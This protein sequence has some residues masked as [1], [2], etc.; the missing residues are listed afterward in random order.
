MYALLWVILI[1]SVTVLIGGYAV[2]AVLPRLFPA[3]YVEGRAGVQIGPFF[4]RKSAER[5]ARRC[6]L[7]GIDPALPM[8]GGRVVAARQRG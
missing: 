7:A 1:G 3:Y 5:Y 6:G 8:N 4:T 2:V